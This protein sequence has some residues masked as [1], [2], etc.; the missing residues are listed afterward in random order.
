MTCTPPGMLEDVGSCTAEVWAS[1]EVVE[2]CISSIILEVVRIC[3]TSLEDCISPGMLE[4]VSACTE[5]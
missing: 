2:G 5:V 3:T 1:V 4:D